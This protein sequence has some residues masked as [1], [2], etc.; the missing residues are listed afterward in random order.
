LAGLYGDLIANQTGIFIRNVHTG[1]ITKTFK[2]KEFTQFHLMA[3]GRPEDV[4][5][6]CVIHT[7]KEFCCGIGE[8]YIFCLDANKLLQDLVTQGRGPKHRQKFLHSDSENLETRKHNEISLSSP[9]KSDASLCML[10][11][12][13]KW[14]VSLNR[15][16]TKVT[17]KF[18]VYQVNNNCIYNKLQEC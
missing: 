2:W 9:L 10:N 6:I 1:E 14:C 4:K 3:A 12:D 13:T 18:C 5:R 15:M 17:R 8:L 7:S 11:T 16:T